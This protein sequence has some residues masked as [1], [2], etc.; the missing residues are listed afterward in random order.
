MEM[1]L[2]YEDAVAK[3][4]VLAFLSLFTEGGAE[5]VKREG[6]LLSDSDS[7]LTR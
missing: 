6:G 7:C 3:S 1:S 2:R 5:G 4:A